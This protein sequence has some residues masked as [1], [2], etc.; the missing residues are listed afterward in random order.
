MYSKDQFKLE[1]MDYNFDE[2]LLERNNPLINSTDQYL[3]WKNMYL[4]DTMAN[5]IEFTKLLENFTNNNYSISKTNNTTKHIY[6]YINPIISETINTELKT[7]LV[8]QRKLYNH[9]ID[10]INFLNNS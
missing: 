1:F 10:Y 6:K 9:F 8:V 7:I 2:M 4:K 3:C 5:Y